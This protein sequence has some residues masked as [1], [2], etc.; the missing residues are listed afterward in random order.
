MDSMLPLKDKD[1]L[2]VYKKKTRIY[3]VYKR[4]ASDLGTHTDWKRGDGKKIF[5][6]NGNQKKAEVA[7]LISEKIDFKIKTIQE[8][9]KD[10][11]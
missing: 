8:T 9:K 2:N 6:A 3:A 11:T 1:W 4:P 10:T 7:V 5:H